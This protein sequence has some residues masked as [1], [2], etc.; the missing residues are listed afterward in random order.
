MKSRLGNDPVFEVKYYVLLGYL[1][2]KSKSSQL[3]DLSETQFQENE[4]RC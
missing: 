3:T 4:T 2:L 1:H